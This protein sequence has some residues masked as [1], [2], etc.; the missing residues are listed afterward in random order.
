M[1]NRILDTYLTTPVSKALHRSQREGKKNNPPSTRIKSE[2]RVEEKEEGSSFQT[3]PEVED[4]EE[5][6]TERNRDDHSQHYEQLRSYLSNAALDIRLSNRRRRDTTFEPYYKGGRPHIGNSILELD[7]EDGT[8]S[9]QGHTFYPEPGLLELIFEKRPNLEDVTEDDLKKY[10][11]I[12]ELTSAHKM[13]FK[14]SCPFNTKGNRWKYRT[15][16]SRLFGGG[17]RQSKRL[18]ESKKKK[19]KKGSGLRFVTAPDYKY[20]RDPNTLVERLS[21]LHASKTA[22]NNGLDGEIVEIEDELR[23]AG[24]ID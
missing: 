10:K 24:I 6:N 16:I 2:S 23:D 11:T 15:I 18:E 21:L 14:S 12:L 20:W 3:L 7:P 1:R 22:G 9:V 4:E 19:K 8:F 17:E 5:G 13:N